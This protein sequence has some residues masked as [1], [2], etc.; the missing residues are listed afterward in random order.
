MKRRKQKSL[1]EIHYGPEP[2]AEDTRNEHACLN[3]YNYMSD[4]KSC[5]EW[6]SEWMKERGYEK[7][8]YMGVKRLSYVPR[9]AAALARMQSIAVPCM[10]KDNLL[11]PQSTAFIKEH[12]KK[13]INDIKSAKSI[14]EDFYKTKKSK[15]KLSIQDRIQNKADEYAGEIEYKLDCYLDN[16]KKNTFDVFTYLTEEQVSGPVAVKVGDNFHNLEKELQ[17][18]LEG[19][20]DQLKEAYSY[21]SKKGLKDYYKFVA[22]ITTGCDKYADGKKKQRKTRRKKVYT[23]T[24][25]TKKIN[26]KITDTEYHLTSLNPELIVGAMQLWTFNTKT[27]EVTKFVAEDRGGLGVKGTTIQKFNNLSAMKKIGNKTEYFLDRIQEGGKI[28]L[29]KVLDEINT[30]SSKPTGRIN[31]HTILLRTE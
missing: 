6:L 7:E 23:A 13:C 26:Y 25:Q 9:T 20:C 12:V 16:P 3:W 22:S 8:H 29:S 4:N 17:E 30:K 19:T 1:D 11:N 5:G 24:E 18:A 31:E 27:K 10:F 15:P 21:L 2:H 14:K 28:V